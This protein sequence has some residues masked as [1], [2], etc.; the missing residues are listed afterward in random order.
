M[1]QEV[2]AD[3]YAMWP[4]SKLIA[5]FNTD[6]FENDIAGFSMTVARDAAWQSALDYAACNGNTAQQQYITNRDID[7]A[8]FTNRLLH[9]GAFIQTATSILRVFEFGSIPEKINRLRD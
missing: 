2:K 6:K 7:V 5:Q 9:P 4:V 8:A 1:V 3:L